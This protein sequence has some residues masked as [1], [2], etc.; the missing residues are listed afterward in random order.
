MN[1][2]K[3]KIEKNSL[4]HDQNLQEKTER[5][6]NKEKFGMGKRHFPRKREQMLF[7]CLVIHATVFLY[8]IS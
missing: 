4:I 2:E 5:N 8:F 3:E 1:S 6:L 7:V